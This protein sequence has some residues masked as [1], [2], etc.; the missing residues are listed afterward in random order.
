MAIVKGWE[1]AAVY[2]DEGLSGTLDASKRPGL[3]SLLQASC[4][5]DVQAVIVLSLDRLARKTL[6]VLDIVGRLDGCGVELVSVKESLDTSTPSGRFAL[7]MFAAIAQLE[8]D[9]IVARTTDGRN[10]RGR[11]DGER[12][13]TMPLG[14]ERVRDTN[15]RAI[16]VG[17]VDSDAA[18]VR[19]IFAQRAGGAS[20][21]A[22]ADKLNTDGI[23]P[24]RG[25]KWYASSV[26]EV[27][28]NRDCY[29]G[30][31]RWV[32]T[33]TWPVILTD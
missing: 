14:Y 1:V 16:G 32:S 25:A 18:T 17:V 26:R 27:L 29:R 13:G 9:T 21:R 28:D 12:G 2:S 24:R 20:L 30:G 22:I 6:L 31:Q 23:K 8:R 3:K 19:A 10:E 15:G 11:I 4:A 7:T 5:G 33:E